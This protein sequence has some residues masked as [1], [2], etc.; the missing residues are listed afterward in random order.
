LAK[1]ST[2]RK[3]P[4]GKKLGRPPGKQRTFVE[5]G[6]EGMTTRLEK[7]ETLVGQ[8]GPL[9]L[10]MLHAYNSREMLNYIELFNRVEDRVTQVEARLNTAQN[11]RQ[12]IDGSKRVPPQEYG[13]VNQSPFPPR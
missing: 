13:P 9:F 7:G 10:M 6:L 5:R 2:Q 1:S 12:A 3:S 11:L 8:E 4:S